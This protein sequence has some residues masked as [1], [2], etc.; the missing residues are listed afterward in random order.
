[1]KR[2]IL[3]FICSSVALTAATNPNMAPDL[4]LDTN[5][6]TDIFAIPL[7]TSEEEEALELAQM[8]RLQ[9]RIQKRREMKE[10]QKKAAADAATN[11]SPETK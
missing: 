10:A 3:A 1:M 4:N 9:A 7:D 8:E 11:T 2:L 5:D 6:Q